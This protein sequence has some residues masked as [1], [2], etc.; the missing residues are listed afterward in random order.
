M[1]YYVLIAVINSF[2]VIQCNVV[3]YIVA[4]YKHHYVSYTMGIVGASKFREHLLFFLPN[5]RFLP[6]TGR[7]VFRYMILL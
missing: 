2:T 5:K 3:E 4:C 7:K 6:L 1:T